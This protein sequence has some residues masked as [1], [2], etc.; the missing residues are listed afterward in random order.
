MNRLFAVGRTSLTRL[1]MSG[2]LAVLP[3]VLTVAIIGWVA[4]FLRSYLGPD[5]MVGELIRSL[6][7]QL[8]AGAQGTAAYLLGV[9]V[10]V[11]ALI[12]L[13]ILFELGAKQIYQ[14]TLEWVMKKIP[15]VGNLY[16]SL[17]QL[18]E[19]FDK[20]EQTELKAMSVV[21]CYFGSL[22]G[23]GVLALMPSSEVI[24]I[25]GRGHHVVIIPTAPVPFGGGLIFF[26]VE[27]VRKVDM[28]VDQF[29]S[30]YVSM[31]VTTPEFFAKKKLGENAIKSEPKSPP[32]K[33]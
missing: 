22:E 15:L 33:P 13:G 30:I 18:I 5:T 6:G 1:F 29:V 14:S 27:H 21:Y 2:L 28:T 26:P 19:L 8:D 11:A 3:L 9:V 20:S 16:G 4:N 25:E 7:V 32:T 31:G 23:S 24:E 12:G 10:V 17:R